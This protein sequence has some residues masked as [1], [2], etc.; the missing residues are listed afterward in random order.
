MAEALC[1]DCGAH[2][3]AARIAA[4]SRRALKPSDPHV[5]ADADVA[6]QRAQQRT[7]QE[8]VLGEDRDEPRVVAQRDEPDI[9]FETIDR[10][11]VGENE[12][13][14]SDRSRDEPGH[15]A[16]DH[17]SPADKPFRRADALRHLDLLAAAID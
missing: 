9:G 1:T 10:R 12:Q 2:A 11:W 7:R 4:I 5:T 17:E 6:P 15:D 14:E 13:G 8:Q 3:V 16:L